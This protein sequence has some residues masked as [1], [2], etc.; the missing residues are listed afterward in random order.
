MPSRRRRGYRRN[1]QDLPTP[2]PR[3]VKAA[4]SMLIWLPSIR[5]LNV[6]AQ[7]G[8]LES[9]A[10]RGPAQV[11]ERLYVIRAVV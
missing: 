10:V 3:A 8:V 11:W 2:A 1:G 6:S 4:L 5:S 7:M 9:T